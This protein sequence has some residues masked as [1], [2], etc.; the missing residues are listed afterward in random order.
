MLE[1]QPIEES[2]QRRVITEVQRYI[3]VAADY[4]GQ[5]FTAIEVVFDLRGRAAGIY[6]YFYEKNGFSRGWLSKKQQQIR[7]NP[8]IFSKYPE[9]SW[10]N[11]I[12]HEVA[13]YIADCRFGLDKI[14]PHGL[15]WKQIMGD[16]GAEPKVRGDYSL[17]GIPT[18]R[19]HRYD[20]T[21]DCRSVELTAY[22][23]LK[24]QRGIQQ[25]H[26]RDCCQPLVLVG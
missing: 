17:E 16:F 24:I 26:C 19:I 3:T 8:W 20:Y 11:T 25:Y 23:H 18:R 12:P 13:H 9:D 4:Y 6:R 21:C 22:R 14:K 5:P 1:I 15:E 7:F 2:Q 10:T